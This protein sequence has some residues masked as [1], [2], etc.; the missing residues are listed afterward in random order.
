MVVLFKIAC[1]CLCFSF[2]KHIIRNNSCIFRGDSK[3][4]QPNS[5]AP[6]VLKAF[7]ICTGALLSP[8]HFPLLEVTTSQV[9]SG[10]LETSLPSHCSP[11]ATK[12]YIRFSATADSKTSKPFPGFQPRIQAYPSIGSA[13][14]HP[15][16]LTCPDGGIPRV[17]SW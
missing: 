12:E 7:H 1:I 8:K 2:N 16:S 17:A 9:L 5:K 15:L 14:K 13:A 10:S 3:N 4:K 11:G 6:C